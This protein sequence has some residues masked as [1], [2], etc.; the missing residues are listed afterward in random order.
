[1]L[2]S[3][4]TNHGASPRSTPSSAL[5]RTVSSG[6]KRRGTS[7]LKVP[8]ESVSA[9]AASRDHPLSPKMGANSWC[10]P[11]LVTR[12]ARFSISIE[13]HHGA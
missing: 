12:S 6:E 4:A 7:P 13:T 11:C 8:R 3:D 5:R 9:L 2:P 1:M 10:F